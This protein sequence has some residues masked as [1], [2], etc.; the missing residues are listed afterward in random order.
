MRNTE[1]KSLIYIIIDV[2]YNTFDTIHMIQLQLSTLEVTYTRTL[3]TNIHEYIST[4]TMT[5]LLQKKWKVFVAQTATQSRKSTNWNNSGLTRV[6]HSKENNTWVSL[7]QT[8][9]LMHRSNNNQ[10]QIDDSHRN[11]VYPTPR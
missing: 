5:R 2:S 3:S 7:I 4:Y 11:L 6:L 1:N 8:Q 9:L 10:Y